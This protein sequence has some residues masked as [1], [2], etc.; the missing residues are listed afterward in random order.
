MDRKGWGISRKV[1]HVGPLLLLLLPHGVLGSRRRE[2][3]ERRER[4]E[5]REERRGG[6]E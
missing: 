6:R 5:R 1:L 2:R 4:R 3:G